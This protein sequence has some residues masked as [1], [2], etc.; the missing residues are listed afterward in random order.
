[1]QYKHTLML[2]YKGFYL[3]RFCFETI[4]NDRDFV[5]KTA[6]VCLKKQFIL[7]DEDVVS[8]ELFGDFL[9]LGI[10]YINMRH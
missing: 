8:L 1:M 9:E 3:G 10:C 6:L 7:K 5:E 4:Y 2:V